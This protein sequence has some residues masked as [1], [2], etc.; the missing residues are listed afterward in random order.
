MPH[1]MHTASALSRGSALAALAGTLAG[2]AA[3]LQA[4]PP[5][6]AQ[7]APAHPAARALHAL[8]DSAWDANMRRYPEWATYIGDNRFGDR[9]QDAS[10]EAEVAGFDSLRQQ[11]QAALAIDR[12]ALDA[13]DRT[14]LDLFL[15]GLDDELLFEPLVGYRRLTLAANG[16][17]HTGFAGLLRASPVNDAAQAGQVLARL[18]AYPQRVDQ[19]LVRL[20][21]GLALG[22]VAAQ[23]VL[24]RVLATLDTQI[25]ASVD[26]S[27][28]F[29]PFTRL[30]GDIPAA[31]RAALQERARTLVRSQVV[32][33]QQRLRDF[34]AGPYAAAAPP[35]GNLGRYPG[36]AAV[37]Q[38]LARSNTTT[39]LSA[40][41][42]H[43]IGQREVARLQ[44]EIA[45]VMRD[46]AWTG[47]FASFA[48]HL[49]TDPRYFH[50]SADA[51][52]AGYRALG[53]RIDAALPRLFA[54]LPRA[55]WGVRAMPVEAGPD[56][57]EYYEMPGLSGDRPG[58]FNANTLGYKTRPIWAMEALT[59]HEAMPGHHLQVALALE[60]GNLPR[61]RRAN[62]YV[63]FGEGWA[64]YAET[65]G[66]QLGLYNDP[67]S[68]FGFLQMQMLRAVRL[69]I[70]TGIH[71]QGWSR[72]RAIDLFIA[73]TGYDQA[74]AESEID[75]YTSDP[76]Q[77]LGYYI[78]QLKI[79]ELRD[80]ARAAL[81][82][83]FDIRRFHKAVLDQ[84]AVPLTVL[85][86]QIDTWL[87]AERRQP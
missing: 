5:A 29:E 20:R 52:L 31:E 66:P 81:G 37:Y 49:N 62:Y 87:A 48:Q 22:W 34:V 23:P 73:T 11:R 1:P 45:Q 76:G 72:Q 16:G 35:A 84:G 6:T 63:A 83:R 61:F 38:A 75:R 46:M 57:S 19:E 53:Q 39:T 41:Q 77:A 80:R 32:P 51:L 24:Q 9:L 69:V 64:L 2:C 82:Q 55:P 33:A 85:D 42:I 4:P 56:A 25:G 18:A 68:R 27:P 36:G 12:Q 26:Q 3:G 47:D 14:S 21:Q 7:A 17:F 43:A 15:H 28:F 78:G 79:L 40:P 86:Q 67:P 50:T 60:L 59:A 10:P 58:W 8:F 13:T 65:L 54:E 74:Y 70:D 44:G 71:D 30:G